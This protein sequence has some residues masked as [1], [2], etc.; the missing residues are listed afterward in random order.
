LPDG[1]V[2]VLV[3]RGDAIVAPRG[4]TRLH[5][6]DHVCVFVLAEH[7]PLLDL[8]FGQGRNELG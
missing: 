6:G 1:C 5:D 3:V 7:R 8:L 2:L 4:A